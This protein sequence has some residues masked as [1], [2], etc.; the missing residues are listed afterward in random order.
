MARP[1][2]LEPKFRVRGSLSHE[3]GFEGSLGCGG[4]L[5]MIKSRIRGVEGFG[6]LEVQGFRFGLPSP[7]STGR[8]A[9]WC[10]ML[11]W[12]RIGVKRGVQDLGCGGW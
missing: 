5:N 11:F 1:R 7:E 12:G 4:P 10:S 2:W 9:F 6:R 8:G 3:L